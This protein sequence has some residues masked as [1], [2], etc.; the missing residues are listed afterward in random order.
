MTD[1]LI[2]S[3]ENR[4]PRNAHVANR[5]IDFETWLSIAH[6]LD[7]ELIKGVMV[8]R[9]AAHYPHEWIFAW[10]FAL[11]RNYTRSL[12][13]GIVLGSRTAV[14]ID[15]YGGRLP[16]ILF[17]RADNSAIV[18]REAI[19]GAPDLVIE[20]VSPNDSRS[21]Q[22]AL[23]TD[24]CSIGVSEIVFIDPQ[25]K[26]VRLVRKNESDEYDDVTLTSGM[27][28]FRTITGFHVEIEWIFA[29]TQPNEF[30]V[31]AK[32]IQEA[33]SGAA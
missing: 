4:S 29:E 23:E 13:R 28:E 14:K 1:L 21:E 17:V 5:P 33:K 20:I 26:R 31:A 16:D 30:D 6:D 3:E 24:Y 32:L 11:L 25:K 8:D 18:R 10:L 12:N 9:M 19:Y 22:I 15:R 7:T 2:Q 27:L